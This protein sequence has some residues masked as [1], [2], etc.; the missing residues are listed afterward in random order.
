M[1]NIPKKSGF[2]QIP[3][4][5]IIALCHSAPGNSEGSV[6]MAIIRKT[7]GWNKKEDSISVSQLSEMTNYSRRTII[8]AIQNLEAKKMILVN[9]VDGRVNE[10]QIQSDTDQ[11]TPK[12]ESEN[13]QK[14]LDRKRENYHQKPV[15]RNEE[16]SQIVAPVY[17]CNEIDKKDESLH[18]LP[19]QRNDN[20]SATKDQKPVQRNEE[21][22]QIVAP[23]KYTITKDNTKYT[24]QKTVYELP[25]WINSETWEAFLEM[26]K[27]IK[28][29]LTDYAISLMLKKLERLRSAGDDPNEV[30]NESIMNNW[31]GVFALKNKGVKNNGQVHGQNAAG[32]EKRNVRTQGFSDDEY[33]RSLK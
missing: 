4:N 20:T 7:Y 3:N 23:T 2:T 5:L 25:E 6:L 14:E 9:R 12:A 22:S 1:A 11:W 15:Q 16:N 10:I 29:P 21:N 18:P 13:Y 19:V 31:K 30:L 28:E 26:R 27:K 33:H 8:Y 24:I 32:N 17:Q